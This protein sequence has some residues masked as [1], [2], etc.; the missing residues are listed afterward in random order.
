MA[1]E[2]YTAAASVRKYGAIA[3]LKTATQVSRL[4][5]VELDS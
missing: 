1:L 4:V 2:L 5:A 3:S